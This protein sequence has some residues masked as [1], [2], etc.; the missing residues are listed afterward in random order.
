M[1]KKMFGIM[2][3]CTICTILGM[4]AGVKIVTSQAEARTETAV[5]PKQAQAQVVSA[6]NLKE[7]TFNLPEITTNLKGSG[8]VKIAYSF[9]TTNKK[10]Q[11]ELGLRS[12]QINDFIIKNLSDTPLQI[13]QTSKGV[14]DLNNKIK[15]HVNDL[16]EKGQVAE[17]Y[18]T[19]K[20]ISE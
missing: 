14:D 10:S 6:D 8:Y 17:I 16:L 2:L 1:L 3:I 13:L 11:A 18:M 12:S 20:I 9:V 7:Q 5:K 19:S 15:G 4:F